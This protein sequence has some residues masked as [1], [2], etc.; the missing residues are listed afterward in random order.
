MK[1]HIVCISAY[2]TFPGPCMKSDSPTEMRAHL[3]PSLNHHVSHQYLKKV[4][5]RAVH[6]SVC[7]ATGLVVDRMSILAGFHAVRQMLSRE[8]DWKRGWFLS[9]W[10]EVTA[11]FLS[12]VGRIKFGD[13]GKLSFTNFFLV[14]SKN[15]ESFS[16]IS[17]RRRI[18][19]VSDAKKWTGFT[20]ESR[21]RLLLF[22]LLPS[23]Y[24]D[25]SSSV[26]G[27]SHFIFR[28]CSPQPFLSQVQR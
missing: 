27:Y 8:Q 5:L 18:F 6:A 25:L 10:C 3:S 12:H 15:F 2:K 16:R 22:L 13:C 1:K 23:V 24:V 11:N 17:L 20:L 19:Q 21:A 7:S 4:P 26:I 14:H 28:T 9:S